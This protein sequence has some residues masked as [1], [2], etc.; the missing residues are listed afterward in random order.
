MSSRWW[1][2][3]LDQEIA[4]KGMRGLSEE[5]FLRIADENITKSLARKVLKSEIEAGYF[6]EIDGQ[7]FPNRFF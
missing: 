1:L 5:E 6:I 3:Y 7:I 2:N 4:K